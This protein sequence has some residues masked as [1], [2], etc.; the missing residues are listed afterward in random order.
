[1]QVIDSI[2]ERCH[3]AAQEKRHARAAHGD[4]LQLQ[5]VRREA[6]LSAQI[7][8]EGKIVLEAQMNQRA[9]HRSLVHAGGG[10]DVDLR[11]KIRGRTGH[12][13]L[14]VQ[15]IVAATGD[16]HRAEVEV[17]DVVPRLRPGLPSREVVHEF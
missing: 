11:G 13:V 3:A 6:E 15:K 1:M 2:G 16:V 17:I 8:V 10:G 14:A 9:G 5:C 4:R 7:E 12:V